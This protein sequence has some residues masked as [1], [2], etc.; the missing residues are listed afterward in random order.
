[1]E[2]GFFQFGVRE[3]IAVLIAV[4]IIADWAAVRYLRPPPPPP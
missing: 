4:A 3:A 2:P 1:M